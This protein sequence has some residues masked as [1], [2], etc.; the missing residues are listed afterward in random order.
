MWRTGAGRPLHLPHRP[1]PQQRS[2]DRLHAVRKRRP[3]QPGDRPRGSGSQ[4]LTAIRTAAA[5]TSASLFLASMPPPASSVAVSLSAA[6]IGAF[7]TW[8]SQTAAV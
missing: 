6:T 1:H 2:R 5:L 4:R 3:G 7:G 8:S